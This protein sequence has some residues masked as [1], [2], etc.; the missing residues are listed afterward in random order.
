MFLIR[1]GKKYH[2]SFTDILYCPLLTKGSKST[3]CLLSE[4]EKLSSEVGY[5]ASLK[6]SKFDVFLL[7]NY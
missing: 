5:N 1:N 4:N 2:V 6:I 3:Y 7:K